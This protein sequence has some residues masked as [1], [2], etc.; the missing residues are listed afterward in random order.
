[1]LKSEPRTI[2]F[3][4][5]KSVNK[6]KK[7]KVLKFLSECQ[8]V[9]NKLIDYYWNYEFT[10]VMTS[11]NKVAFNY[12]SYKVKEPKIK[13]H[14]HQQLLQ[15]VYHMLKS[16]GNRI[17]N[18]IYFKF[19]DKE[20]QYIY[21]YMAKFTFEWEWL[22]KYVKKQIIGYKK[23]D[24]K[25]LEFLKTIQK[26]IDVPEK[27]EQIKQEIEDKFWETKKKFKKPVKKEFQIVCNTYQ[28]VKNIHIKHFQWIFVIDNNDIIGGTEKKPV[29]DQMIIPVRFSR[30]HKEILEDKTLNNTFILK[31][32]KYGR[33]EIIA[34]YDQEVY[35]PTPQS[36]DVVGIDIGLKKLIVTS[37]GEI[38]EQNKT[39]VK[40]LKKLVRHQSNRNR[41]EKHLQKK[42]GEC[43]KLSDKN[44]MKKQR[45]LSQ[46]VKCENRFLIKNF[47]LSHLTDH[48]II[49]DLNIA[50][51]RT[52]HKETNYL[53]KR[54][55][56][57]QIKNYL[58]EYGKK[59]GIKVTGVNEAYT[60]QQCS[61]CGY[62]SKN[63]R[64][65]QEMF[66]C[67]KCDFEVNAD[68]NAA[69]NIKNRYF[70]KRIKLDTPTWRVKEI[71]EMEFV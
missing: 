61:K 4:L 12:N 18:S 30:Y 29:F 22:E 35:Y 42:Y 53:L 31:L 55:G 67:G 48:L 11:R 8:E 6:S 21:N 52:H 13:S 17:R 19:E 39:I 24:K 62:I 9:E 65:S 40:R 34:T 69:I 3:Y 5:D 2:K 57:Q 41:L 27:Y 51:S 10:K 25:Y 7:D 54:M 63:N 50:Y 71:L 33:I 70:D 26:I 60:S 47:L 32:N 49:E 59:L 1:M 43:Y 66:S 44:Y 28:T 45:K 20:K 68:L 58:V 16:I 36:E 37:D 46:F 14:H 64:K 23:D 38:I 56:V 15:Q